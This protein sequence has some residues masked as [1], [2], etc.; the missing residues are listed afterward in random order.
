MSDLPPTPWTYE[1]GHGFVRDAHR[2][3]VAYACTHDVGSLL[4]AAPALRDALEALRESTRKDG[5]KCYDIYCAQLINNTVH[6][7]DRCV[8]ARTALAA[9]RE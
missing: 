3:A 1:K 9:C 8:Q 7:T 6:H 4:A 2:N 5:L